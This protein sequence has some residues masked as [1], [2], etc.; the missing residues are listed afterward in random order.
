MTGDTIDGYLGDE[1]YPSNFHR[2]FTPQWIDAMLRH[3]SIAPPRRTA[4]QPFALLDLGCGDGLGLVA[5]AAAHPEGRFL[6]IDALP[7]HVARGTAFAAGLGIGNVEFRCALFADIADPAVPDFDYVTAQGVLAWVSPANRD[8]LRRIAAAQLKPGGIACIGYNCMP[9]WAGALAFQQVVWMLAEEKQG[10]ALQRYEAAFAQIRELSAA[11]ASS[12]SASFMAWVDNLR[13]TVPAAYFP[14]EYLNRHW[15][16]LWSS[17]VH[18]DLAAQGLSFAGTSRSELLRPDFILRKAQRAALAAIAGEAA[19]EVTMDAMLGQSFHIDL[20]ARGIARVDEAHA[21]RLG[22]WWAALK[23]E[24][25]TIYEARTHAGTLRFD[26]PAAHA[27]MNA[28]GEG[29]TTVAGIAARGFEGTGA[30]LLNAIDA[31]WMSGQIHPC[32]PPGEAPNA[33][34]FNAAIRA[35]AVAGTAL[36][37]LV[38]RHGAMPVDV[39]AIAAVEKGE[40]DAL[41]LMR[42][43]A[44]V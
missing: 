19:R 10:S 15:Q 27:V 18:A 31:L 39:P 37:A 26:N 6:G 32:D 25:N 14:H 3:R 44:I 23:S 4:R 13:A 9:G 11:G 34:A 41:A 30:D 1:A 20:F 8:H 28:L 2:Q 35:Q 24:A 17:E 12:F 5:I 42:R 43:L 21:A 40:P 36:P 38:G 29:P 22:G 16:P 33:G 7:D